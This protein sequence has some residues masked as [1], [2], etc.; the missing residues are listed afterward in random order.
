[1]KTLMPLSIYP[2]TLPYFVDAT[3]DSAAKLT[4]AKEEN[5]KR[6]GATIPEAIIA[7]FCINERRS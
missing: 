6:Q 2:L 1:L 3:G 5:F 4:D 7:D